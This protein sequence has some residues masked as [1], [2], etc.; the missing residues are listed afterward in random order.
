MYTMKDL[1][2]PFPEVS[3]MAFHTWMNIP[4]VYG[5]ERRAF[6]ECHMWWASTPQFVSGTWMGYYS[7]ERVPH[8]SL[9]EP[10]HSINLIARR[11]DL[12]K[13]GRVRTIIDIAS[14]GHD[15]VGKFALHGYIRFDGSVLLTKRHDA[16]WEWIYK[17]FIT[18]FGIAG[19]W[20]DQRLDGLG[21]FWL[22]KKDWCNP[23]A[24]YPQCL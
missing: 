4:M 17:G 14:Q 3:R 13:P 18:P 6:H 24:N 15:G 21:Y 7:D 1:P 16:G 11:S 23:E 12:S 8:Q 22:W 9:E 19:S 10:M 2:I 20:G 5:S